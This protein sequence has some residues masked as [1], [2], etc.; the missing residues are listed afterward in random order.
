M[1]CTASTA[2]RTGGTV[3]E[4]M[5]ATSSSDRKLYGIS[6]VNADNAANPAEIYLNDGTSRIQ[7]SNVNVAANAGNNTSTSP[8][9]LFTSTMG[10]SVFGK[11]RDMNGLPYMNIPKNW[12]VELSYTN[13]PGAG[14][15]FYTF[16]F[17]EYY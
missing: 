7:I 11:M 17:G 3:F 6:V 12:S 5:S 13:T 1:Q 10:E 14:E 8:V 15:T 2:S 9:N 16:A 4:I